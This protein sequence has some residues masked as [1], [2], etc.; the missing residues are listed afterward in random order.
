M[1][2]TQPP[3]V[4]TTPRRRLDKSHYLYIAVI[5]AVVAGVIVGLASP[6]T[7]VALKPLG[8]GFVALIKMMI[9]PV[10][11]CTIVLGIGSIAKA[12][13][14]G[15]VGGLALLYFI[16]MSTFALFIG[17]V[18]GNVLHPGEGL[19]VAGVSYEA[20]GEASSTVDFLLGIIPTTLVSPLSGESVLQTLFVALLVGFGIQQLGTRGKPALEAVRLIQSIVFR[21]LTMIL[22]VAPVGAFGAIAAVVGETGWGAVVQL[23]ILMAGFYVTCILFIVVV[24]GT[25]LRLAS[26]VNIFSLMKYLAREYLLIVSTSSSEAALPRLI[27]KMEHLGVSKPV[28]GITVPTGYS[29]NLDGTAIY[30]TMA[31]LFIASALGTPMSIPEQIGMLAFMIIASKGAAGVTGAGLATLAGG[32]QT[33]RPDLVD[34]VGIIVGIDRFM[35]EARAV[36]NF[37]GNAVATVVIGTWTKEIDRERVGQVLAGTIPFDET[38]MDDPHGGPADAENSVPDGGDAPANGTPEGAAAGQN[39]SPRTKA[40]EPT[41]V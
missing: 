14:V 4:G 19:S 37:T 2:A 39:G 22:W 8:T 9:S 3:G 16:V 40:A 31:S 20:E 12:A 32:L 18:V 35:S 27:A 36:T 21:V 17:L 33:Y 13:T 15:R 6:E 1:A 25:V 7:G 34:G 38:A 24:L 41:A 23:G 29:F 30:L 10:I 11:F 26:G 28:V 5:V